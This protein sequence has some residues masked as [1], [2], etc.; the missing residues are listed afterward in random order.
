[1]S[2][3]QGVNRR[4]I[5]LS[6]LPGLVFIAQN[7]QQPWG[8]VGLLSKFCFAFA[9]FK[10]NVIIETGLMIGNYLDL[11]SKLCYVLEELKSFITEN[12]IIC[13]IICN[14]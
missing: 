2:T 14:Y 7:E 12:L 10:K 11:Y 4:H 8:P 1:M 6:I 9:G 13:L 3:F 5:S